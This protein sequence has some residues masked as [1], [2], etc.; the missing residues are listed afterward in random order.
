MLVDAY[1]FGPKDLL[2]ANDDARR[3]LGLEV[4]EPGEAGAAQADNARALAE[5]EQMMKGMG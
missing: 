4:A 1:K 2:T 5:L 3:V